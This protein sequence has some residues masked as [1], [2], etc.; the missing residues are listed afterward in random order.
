MFFGKQSY[1]R[2]YGQH[3]VFCFYISDLII[4]TLSWLLTYYL[5]FS[6]PNREIS[7]NSHYLYAIPFILILCT[8]TFEHFNL[9]FPRRTKSLFDE[10]LIILK[11][12]SIATIVFLVFSFF[13]SGYDF[14]RA[15]IMLFWLI[16]TILLIISHT[17]IRSALMH[18]RK[19]GYDTNNVII[20]GSGEIGRS[21]LAR[22]E[23][24]AWM[25]LTV[26][27]FIDDK[28]DVGQLVDGK[29]VL[30]RIEELKN[31]LNNNTIDQI[32]IALPI[33]AFHKVNFI[34]NLLFDSLVT[35]HLIPQIKHLMMNPSIQNFDGLPIITIMGNPIQ[36][37]KA[38]FKR[39]FDIIFAIFALVIS[40]P[41]FL[42]APIL[43]KM[44][45]TGPV[46]FKQERIG[47]N[48]KLFNMLKFRT[49]KVGSPE[50]ITKKGD[51]RI[52]LVGKFLRKF[53]L[54]EFPQFVNVL[55][56][57]MTVV[58]PRPHMTTIYEETKQKIDKY[59]TRHYV[60]PGIT[61]WSQINAYRGI[62]NDL[63]VN[64]E[65]LDYDLYYIENWSLF[66]D[67]KIIFLTFYKG[68]I[69]RAE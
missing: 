14:S 65:R 47:H 60:K 66:L 38:G 7:Q 68:F 32:F 37:L 12:I 3:L 1:L 24:N 42:F 16:S 19:K 36:G 69:N 29:K 46:F 21:L 53:S 10:H 6:G 44:E 15:A 64:E 50:D 43:I 59:V 67:L 34:M 4:I 62:T 58:G 9:Y 20:I 40:T 33:R 5:R 39:L 11:A 56:G 48:G 23:K 41:L 31:I 28:T 63:N 55:L 22:I 18:V 35:V 17:I 52:T 30:G 13:I 54:D 2:R 8:I 61:G 27:G 45:S 57:D 51:P 26:R 49:M 25:G